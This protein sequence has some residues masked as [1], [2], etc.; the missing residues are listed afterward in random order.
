MPF[1]LKDGQGT[2]FK[3]TKKDNERQP[4]YSGEANVGGTVYRISGWK[5]TSTHGT[6]WLSLAIEPPRE[7]QKRHTAPPPT[8]QR[9]PGDDDEDIPW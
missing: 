9:Q 2:L 6:Q 8:K 4:D 3:N 7:T 1:Q 5:K